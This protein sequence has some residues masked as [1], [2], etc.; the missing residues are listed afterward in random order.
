MS[1]TGKNSEPGVSER[2]EQFLAAV[3]RA[4]A[5]SGVGA[6]ERANVKEDLRV[7]IEEMMSARLGESGRGATVADVDAVLGELDPPESYVQNAEG[8]EK[9]ARE[10]GPRQGAGCSGG[11]GARWFW[12]RRRVASAIRQAM[13]NFGPFADPVFAG[14][15]PRARRAL[16]LAKGEAFR[17]NHQF[18]GTEHLVL[19]L[20]LEGEGVGGK[21]LLDLGAKIERAREEAVK[22]VGPGHE[23]VTQWMLPVTPRVKQALDFARTEARTLGH[24]FVGTEHVL[25]GILDTA[26]DSVGWQLLV[27]LGITAERVRAEVLGRVPGAA[28]PGP[29]SISYWPAKAAR[30]IKIGGN[31]YRIIASSSD[32]GG[33]YAAVEAV[34]SSPDGLGMRRHTREDISAYVLEGSVRVLMAERTVEMGQGDF[35]RIPRGVGHEIQSTGERARV[36]LIATPAGIEKMIGEMGEAPEA[37]REVARRHGVEGFGNG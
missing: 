33:V 3:E 23:P 12:G 18:I 26:P 6:E 2:I 21:V 31:A 7:Q 36:M 29:Q 10:C 35:V 20:I 27:N 34:I 17:M 22:M 37:M 28:P 13:Q 8:V 1:E 9:V 16:M 25:L 24:D 4:L 19:G 14:L 11:R 30:E 32:T 15:T 5:E